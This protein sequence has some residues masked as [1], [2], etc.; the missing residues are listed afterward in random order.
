[1][2]VLGRIGFVC[3][4]KM[5]NAELLYRFKKKNLCRKL[6]IFVTGRNICAPWYFVFHNSIKLFKTYFIIT[7]TNYSAYRVCPFTLHTI[8]W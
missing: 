4:M 6:E 2:F 3:P 7:E 8:L 5:E 1:M